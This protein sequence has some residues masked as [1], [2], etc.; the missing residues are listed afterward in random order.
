VIFG[1]N[2]ERWVFRWLTGTHHPPA[3]A[4]RKGIKGRRLAASRETTARATPM[5]AGIAPPAKGAG[6]ELHGH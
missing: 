4:V 6:L 2:S 3:W 1:W 5:P